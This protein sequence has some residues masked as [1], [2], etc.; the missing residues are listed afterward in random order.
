M[1]GFTI[2]SLDTPQLL[3]PKIN[4]VRYKRFIDHY[5]VNE[6]RKGQS[7]GDILVDLIASLSS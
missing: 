5:L 2:D 4:E 3:I 1:C 7:N 6:K